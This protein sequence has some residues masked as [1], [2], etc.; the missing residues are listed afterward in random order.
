[1]GHGHFLYGDFAEKVTFARVE[2]KK[3]G[4]QLL[5]FVVTWK[6]RPNGNIPKESEFTNRELAKL[7]PELLIQYYETKLKILN[8]PIKPPRETGNKHPSAT[9]Q[10]A[11]PKTDEV[12]LISSDIEAAA[13]G[14][15]E[16]DWT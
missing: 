12:H 10:L 5:Y 14:K 6:P 4:D 15:R 8:P 11:P 16:K 7:N 1:M 9:T 13:S 3:T 2:S